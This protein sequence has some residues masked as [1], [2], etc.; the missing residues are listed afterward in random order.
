MENSVVKAK[1]HSDAG[2]AWLAVSIKNLANLKLLEDISPWSYIKGKTA[3]L[4]EDLDAGRF[5]NAIRTQCVSVEF[6]T[7]K[8]HERSPI[9]SY[10]SFT[11]EKAQSAISD[12]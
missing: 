5:I 4:E 2:H 10:E 6:S 1:W 3:Y 11:K 12:V 9:R 7:A 8:Y